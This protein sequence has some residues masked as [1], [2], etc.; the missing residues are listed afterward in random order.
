MNIIPKMTHQLSR[1]WDQPNPDNFL[2]DDTHVVMSERDFKWLRDYSSSQPSGVYD[3]KMWKSQWNGVW[4]LRW[5]GPSDRPGF[6]ST[7]FREIIV[8]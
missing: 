6:C 1:Y 5:F 4:D 7:F 2:I 8:V 3:G